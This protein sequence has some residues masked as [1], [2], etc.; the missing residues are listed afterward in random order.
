M[1]NI[2]TCPK[3]LYSIPEQETGIYIENTYA[4]IAPAYDE[5]LS[6]AILQKVVRFKNFSGGF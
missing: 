1:G 6:L 2:L 3:E 5:L 4:T